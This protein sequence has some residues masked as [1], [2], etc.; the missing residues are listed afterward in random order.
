MIYP[1][2]N[3]IASEFVELCSDIDFF[4]LSIGLYE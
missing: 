3:N 1:L 2:T 4:R